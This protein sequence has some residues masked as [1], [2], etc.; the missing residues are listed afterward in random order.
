M[1]VFTYLLFPS[2]QREDH[3][4]VSHRGSQETATLFRSVSNT[5]SMAE[6]I[7]QLKS[8]FGG[9]RVRPIFVW[10]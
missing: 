9:F 6:L 4:A 3:R 2:D 10:R 1:N 8:A 7:E 5:A